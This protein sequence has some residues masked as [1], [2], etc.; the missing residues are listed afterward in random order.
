MKIILTDG[1]TGEDTV[2][3]YADKYVIE[4]GRLHLTGLRDAGRLYA[5]SIPLDDHETVGV[6]LEAGEMP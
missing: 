5:M 4:G 1:K 6:E 3:F 2:V